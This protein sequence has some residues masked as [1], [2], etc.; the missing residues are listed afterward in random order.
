MYMNQKVTNKRLKQDI[1]SSTILIKNTSDWIKKKLKHNMR[2]D[3]NK[4][5]KKGDTLICF[6]KFRS[7]DPTS[8]LRGHKG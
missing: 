2:D 6:S 7:T 5:S 1:R 3:K 8:P 4:Q